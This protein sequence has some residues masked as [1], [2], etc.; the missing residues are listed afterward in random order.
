MKMNAGRSNS[1]TLAGA[2]W[3]GDTN[4]TL[5]AIVLVAAGVLLMTLS[6]KVRVPFVPVPVTLQTLALPLIAAAYGSRLGTVTIIGYLAAGIVGLPVFTNTPPLAAGPL[7]FLGTT[8]GYL[9]AYPL[10]AWIVGAS[11]ESGA[12]RS[13]F[14]LF[15]AMLAGDVLILTVGYLWLAFAA[16]L[17]SGGTGLGPEAAFQA[18]VLPF[19]LAD[20]VKV[21]LAAALTR[22]SW[23]LLERLRG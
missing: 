3:P 4:A 17:A 22:V 6:A 5:R 8:G 13:L 19:L 16:H 21:G 10:A 18:G 2:I 11:S 14:A 20:L 15:G 1:P 23:G 7:Y 9:A 12:G